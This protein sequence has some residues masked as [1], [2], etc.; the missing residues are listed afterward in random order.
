MGPHR[1]GVAAAVAL[2]MFGLAA[3]A[4]P[5]SSTETDQSAPDALSTQ[6]AVAV[7]RRPNILLITTDDQTLSDMQY[8]PLTRRAIGKPG[9]TFR[10]MLSPHPLCCP[11][12]AEILTG[13]YAQNNGVRSNNPSRYGGYPAL[14]NRNTIATWLQDAGYSTAFVGKYLNAYP[15][16]VTRNE[17]GWDIWNPAIKHLY[18]YFDYTMYNNGA[19]KTYHRLHQADLVGQKTSTYIRQLSKDDQP[20]FIWSSHVAPHN[21]CARRDDDTHCDTPP[22]PARRHRNLFRNESSPSLRDPAFNES[23]VSDKPP[24]IAHLRR[25]DRDEVNQL[26]RQRIRALQ[27]VDEAVQDA[28][29]TLRK[30]GE[31]DN[32]LILFTTDNAFLLGEH[33]YLRKDVPYEQAMRTPLMMRGPGIPAGQTRDQTVTL[34]DLAPT[35]VDVA[36]A[37]PT[38]EMDGRSLMPVARDDAAGH[39]TVLIQAGPSGDKEMP[40]GWGWRGVRTSRYT[41]VQ[42]PNTG[43]VELYDRLVD[44][45]ELENVADDPAYASI[46]QELE[47][48]TALLSTCRGEQCNATFGPL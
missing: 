43:F 39:E 12:R 28:V 20:F 26:F 17:L 37:T 47:A 2:T 40:A 10:E 11:A 38:I 4:R 19:P 44:P 30:T 36:R 27:A 22:I 42:Y 14:D 34:V 29:H 8:M 31:L 32:T 48:R 3:L 5:A 7:D 9:V 16:K 25:V 35:L 6:Q 41:Y 46:R 23:D 33:R 18:Q 24:A 13:Q 1:F 15:K 45:A 21:S